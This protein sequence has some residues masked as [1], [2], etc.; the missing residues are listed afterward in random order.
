MKSLTFGLGLKTFSNA[1]KGKPYFRG[2]LKNR[3]RQSASKQVSADQ[4]FTFCI[5]WFVSYASKRHNKSNIFQC[6][7]KRAYLYIRGEFMIDLGDS[8]SS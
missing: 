6:I 3:S 7:S 1:Y 2:G 4:N 8:N 5:Y